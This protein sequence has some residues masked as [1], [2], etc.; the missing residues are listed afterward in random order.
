MEK[1][2]TAKELCARIERLKYKVQS[3]Q[4]VCFF[5]ES[6][7]IALGNLLIQKRILTQ[8]ELEQFTSIVVN[9]K[10]A[11]REVDKNNSNFHL[12]KEE[13]EEALQQKVQQ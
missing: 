13:F 10:I 5:L 11:Q 4:D 8:K 6:E 9:Q 7:V 12:L 3:L 2:N 1:N